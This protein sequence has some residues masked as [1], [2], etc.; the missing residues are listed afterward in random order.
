MK[1][2]RWLVLSLWVAALSGFVSLYAKGHEEV[3]P[4]QLIATISIPGFGNG[5]D[6]SWVD[7]RI[8]NPWS[9]AGVRT[10]PVVLGHPFAKDPSEMSLVEWDQPVQA[11]PTHRADQ[12]PTK[13]AFACGVRTGVLS[14]RRLI[15]AIARSTSAA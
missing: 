15:E 2:K 9:Q 8:G 7:S 14:T 11:L 13:K 12:S 10:T 4:Y 5:F 6:I 1:Q 3:G